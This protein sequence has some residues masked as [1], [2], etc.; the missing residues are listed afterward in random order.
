M[1]KQVSEHLSIHSDKVPLSP[2]PFSP[3]APPPET[4]PPAVDEDKP[5]EAEIKYW[6]AVKE[7]P[8]DF[9]SWTCLLQ[10]VEQKVRGEE[11]T[12]HPRQTGGCFC[13]VLFL[14]ASWIQSGRSLMP[15]WGYIL[16]VTVTGR[17]M[18]TLRGS[19]LAM[20]QPER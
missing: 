11:G 3:P 20:T 6:S 13:Y 14:R 17:N 9:S 1:T 2:P 7:T 19:I 4:N 18:L 5:S 15:F 16:T 10:L 12:T 8:S